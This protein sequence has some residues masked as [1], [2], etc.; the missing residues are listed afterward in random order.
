MDKVKQFP[1]GSV[2]NFKMTVCPV[3]NAPIT[4]GR[5]IK[6]CRVPGWQ[7]VLERDTNKAKHYPV[8]L[9]VVELLS[10]GETVRVDAKGIIETTTLALVP[11]SAGTK[12]LPITQ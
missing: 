8:K 7:S 2:V 12:L 4:Q 10:S 3:I 6:Y 5:L 1:L 9:A 11:A